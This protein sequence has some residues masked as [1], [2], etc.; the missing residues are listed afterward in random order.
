MSD[1]TEHLTKAQQARADRAEATRLDAEAAAD[2]AAAKT[3][4]PSG[5]PAAVAYGERVAKA[6]FDL[7]E[8]GH[9]HV[10]DLIDEL[11]AGLLKLEG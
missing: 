5:V 2:A 3:G 7:R 1:D 9:T 6:H 4:D 8:L 11:Y 10:D